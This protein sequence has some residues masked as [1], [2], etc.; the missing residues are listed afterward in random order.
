[1]LVTPIIEKMNADSTLN[2]SDT[3]NLLKVATKCPYYDGIAVYQARRALY[4]L[5]YPLMAPCR[6]KKGRNG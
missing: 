1:M 5:G 6:C 2:G 3:A 4:Q